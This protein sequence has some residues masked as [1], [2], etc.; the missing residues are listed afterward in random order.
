M[1]RT[2]VRRSEWGF[3]LFMEESVRVDELIDGKSVTFHELK[4]K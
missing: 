4:V 2:S 1:K 3:G